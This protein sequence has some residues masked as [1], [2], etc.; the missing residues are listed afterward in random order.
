M[1]IKIDN[2][3]FN[4]TAK[5]ITFTDYATIQ[6]D[7]I[8]GVINA[9]RG[10]ILFTPIDVTK[11]GTVATNVLTLTYDTSSMANT[12]ELLIYYYDVN[13]SMKVQVVNQIDLSTVQTTL[14]NILTKV[15]AID[16][17][18]DT[19]ESKLTDVITEIDA[20]GTVNNND[21]LNVITELQGIDANTDTLEASLTSIISNTTGNATEVKQDALNALITSI[22]SYYKAEDSPSVSGD[23][24]LPLLAVRQLSDTTSTDTDGDYTLLKIDEEGRLKVSAKPASYP[25]ITGDITNIQA[26]IGTPVAGGT[27]SGDVSR[28]SNVML[29]CT[30]T[31][32][33]VNVTFEGSLEATGDTNWFGVQAVRSNANTVETTTGALSAQPVYGW[34]L[35]VNALKRIRVRAT[36]RTSGTQSW[37]IVQGTYATE[38]IPAIQTTGTQA[39]S[40]TSTTITAISAGT[41]AIGDFGLQARANATGA[42]TPVAI[43]S[44]ATPVGQII[45]AGAGRVFSFHLSNSNASPRF[46]KVFNA[47]AV[48]MGTTSALYE[49]EIPANRVPVTISLPLS[50]G[51]TTGFAVAVTGARGLTDN[52]AITLND[53]TGFATFA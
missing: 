18:T 5:T 9:T 7:C 42:P 52:T 44:P 3:T 22:D 46:L 31:F 14:A 49:I 35:S 29:F 13:A 25:D 37:R 19:I 43:N 20:N 51:A 15:T 36:A 21:L 32:A 2:Y 45:K 53:V 4:K 16:V 33:G 11:G 34:E 39:V 17:N 24:G 26:T 28:A 23:K 27:V 48:T 47:T 30:G 10:V 8:L 12:D 50:A 1:K 38:P 40:L 6:L 41:T